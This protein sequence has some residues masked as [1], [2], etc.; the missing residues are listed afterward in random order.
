MSS[1]SSFLEDVPGTCKQGSLWL[2]RGNHGE[3][4]VVIDSPW[5]PNLGQIGHVWTGI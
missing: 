5:L 2:K 1:D 3:I 4:L